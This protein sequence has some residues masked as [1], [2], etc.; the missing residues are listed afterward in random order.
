MK[1]LFTYL[2]MLIISYWIVGIGL[3]FLCD[4]YAISENYVIANALDVPPILA[5]CVYYFF[6]WTTM[7]YVS[8]MLMRLIFITTIYQFLFDFKE[9]P[10]RVYI[11]GYIYVLFLSIFTIFKNR[12]YE[13][14]NKQL[15]K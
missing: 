4:W 10:L 11:F 6:N 15:Q 13:R 2:P 5:C 9:F 8:K 12:Y 1:L 14:T 7:P 3:F